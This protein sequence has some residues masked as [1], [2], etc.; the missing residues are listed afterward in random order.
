MEG[1]NAY[2]FARRLE[3]AAN[4]IATRQARSVLDLG[5]GTGAY[6]LAPLARRYPSVRFVGVDSDAASI[7]AA[8]RE[9]AGTNVQLFLAGQW[10]PGERF[11]LVIAS[12]V[13]E[14]VESPPEFLAQAAARMAEGGRLLLT[15]PN[16]YGSAE[17]ASLAEALLRLTGIYPGLRAF[18]RLAVPATPVAGIVRDS[19]AVSPHINFF[20][21]GEILGLIHAAGMRVV[22]Y[23]PR[24][25]L[26]GFGWDLLIRGEQRTGW[27][28]RMADRL[29][30]S[31]VADWMFLLEKAGTPGPSRFSRGPYARLRRW[32]NEKIARDA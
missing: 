30:P 16:G 17:W 11:D 15:L 12:E 8:R 29:P 22:E 9:T 18:K 13:V 27:N 14:H 21:H 3:F 28:Q 23:Q 32:M 19:H 5:C 4:A 7:E 20:S 10:P 26:C 31:M 6:L 25:F 24:S 2:G 1:E